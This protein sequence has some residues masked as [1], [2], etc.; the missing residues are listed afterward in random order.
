MDLFLDHWKR[1]NDVLDCI[2]ETSLSWS[3]AGEDVLKKITLEIK[4]L[5]RIMTLLMIGLIISNVILLP[6]P[7]ICELFHRMGEKYFERWIVI[8]DI[9]TLILLAMTGYGSGH[10]FLK[11]AYAFTH[12]KFQCYLLNGLLKNMSDY[13]G[14]GLDDEEY[15]MI[16]YQKL[17]KLVKAH[18]NTKKLFGLITKHF[19]WMIHPVYIANCVAMVSIIYIYMLEISRGESFLHP[20]V[21]ITQGIFGFALFVTMNH[22]QRLSDE[23]EKIFHNVYACPWY[24]WNKR[25]KQL[26]L[27]LMTNSLQPMTL[28]SYAMVNLDYSATVKIG[29]ISWSLMAVLKTLNEKYK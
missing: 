22:G 2:E 10:F 4:M 14:K 27:S 13:T 17:V 21:L 7:E 18:Q 15:Q 23:F 25:N 20:R 16:T 26:I 9:M 24:T 3:A 1:S 29:K 12:T 19:S 6:Y 28:T 11:V 8:I 5:K